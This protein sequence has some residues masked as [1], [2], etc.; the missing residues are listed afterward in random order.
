M[1]N[2]PHLS[3]DALNPYKRSVSEKN[4]TNHFF[5]HSINSNCKN[6]PINP[7]INKEPFLAFQEAIIRQA[8]FIAIV[9]ILIYIAML[10]FVWAMPA[11][12]EATSK[13]IVNPPG[14][15]TFSL[16]VTPQKQSEPDDIETQA[17]VLRSAGLALEVVRKL[18]LDRHPVILKKD[19]L[20]KLIQTIHADVLLRLLQ[21]TNDS[22]SLE[23]DAIQ[24]KPEELRGVEYINKH[25]TV[26]ALRNSRVIEMKVR[27]SD[28]RLS[29]A[30]ANELIREFIE[31]SYLARYADVTTSSKCLQK[32][33]TEIEQRAA[34]SRAAL[35]KFRTNHHIIDPD[36]KMD[37]LS[38]NMKEL[39]HYKTLSE[40][41]SINL[42]AILSSVSTSDITSVPQFLDN[43]MTQGILNKITDISTQLTQ[44]SVYYDDNHPNIVKLKT[45]LS[46]LKAKL[47]EHRNR[48]VE[49]LSA[50]YQ[51]AEARS[52]SLGFEIQREDPVLS[53]ISEYAALR[54]QAE[55]DENSYYTLYA[56]FR[57]AVVSA[58]SKS[59]NIKLVDMA[60]IPSK[61]VWP[62]FLLVLPIGLAAA[63]VGGVAAGLAR[64]GLDSSVRS[65]SDLKGVIRPENVVLIPINTTSKHTNTRKSSYHGYIT[66][67]R[68]DSHTIDKFILGQPACVASESIRSL[69]SLMLLNEQK[70]LAGVLLVTSSIPKEGKTTIAF[71]LAAALSQKGATC[72]INAD[73]RKAEA[74]DVSGIFT[75]YKDAASAEEIQ[76]QCEGA[77][78]LTYVNSGRGDENP[79]DVLVSDKFQNLVATIR[80]AYR[81][82][83]IDSPPLLAYADA[84]VLAAMADFA[85][86]VCFEGHTRRK[87]VESAAAVLCELS[88]PI[89]GVALNGVRSRR[90][91]YGYY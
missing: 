12:Y 31:N 39:I 70:R 6:Q 66:K 87:S 42:K 17:E 26:L 10:V 20:E 46:D 88:V 28:R 58:G 54:R 84:R 23:P 38:G 65:Q 91:V 30:I 56:S 73:L 37:L 27:S 77:L 60:I 72:L 24:V 78:N 75:Y 80:K 34:K 89:V 50:S 15:E 62:T 22:S 49:Q 68:P 25:M 33:L 67:D 16:V 11:I 8:A 69:M 35:I 9:A 64:N 53:S 82:V 61:P 4:L 86:L 43:N 51:A 19:Y 3:N 85:I 71:N 59:A 52:K 13:I 63:C 14:S 2:G 29:A 81:F 40:S 83:V 32:E 1:M 36:D 7:I 57:Q 48:Y 21:Q 44:A 41:E 5:T 74:N 55:A 90:S 18:R 79:I 45:E 76:I 47:S